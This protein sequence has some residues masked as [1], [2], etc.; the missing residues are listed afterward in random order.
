MYNICTYT[1]IRG[2]REKNANASHKYL[3][4][5]WASQWLIGMLCKHYDPSLL[6]THVHRSDETG[7]SCQQACHTSPASGCRSGAR[8]PQ[9]W[10]KGVGPLHLRAQHKHSLPCP[11][12]LCR[13]RVHVHKP[14]NS[15]A[16]IAKLEHNPEPHRI[17]RHTFFQPESRIR[18]TTWTLV[19]V[20]T[21]QT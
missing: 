1:Y 10:L 12:L 9:Q 14:K 4:Q 15:S 5:W 2:E 18:T 6:N 17:P 19:R 21:I 13:L 3:L 11:A 16:T 7:H 8:E 20:F